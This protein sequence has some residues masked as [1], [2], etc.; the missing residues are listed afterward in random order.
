MKLLHNIN[1]GKDKVYEEG[2][3]ELNNETLGLDALLAEAN[4]NP[5][6]LP[7]RLDAV[8]KTFEIDPLFKTK[9]EG[10]SSVLAPDI[11]AF[12][13]AELKNTILDGKIWQA[14]EISVPE[15]VRNTRC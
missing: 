9:V 11:N 6:L 14:G 7:T 8:F 13:K 5:G 1:Y 10:V 3:T 4:V 2:T 15:S 12:G